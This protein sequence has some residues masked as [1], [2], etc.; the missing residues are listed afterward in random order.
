MA[1]RAQEER[2]VGWFDSAPL[3]VAQV[4]F[5]IVR[6]RLRERRKPAETQSKHQKFRSLVKAGLV[7]DP[8][9]TAKILEA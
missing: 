2:I 3:E 5:N 4:V 1:K 6:G 8:V 9:E 7:V